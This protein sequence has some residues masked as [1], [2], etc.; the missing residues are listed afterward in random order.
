M[1]NP[2][3]HNVSKSGRW[4]PLSSR[5][6]EFDMCTEMRRATV[7]L[8]RGNPPT[9]LLGLLMVNREPIRVDEAA[10]RLNKPVEKVEWVAEQLAEEDLCES[11]TKDG[12]TWVFGF[13]AFNSRNAFS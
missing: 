6:L 5:D 13:A 7:D 2:T 8:I 3:K 12:V 4:I 9:N 10:E 1:N 11:I